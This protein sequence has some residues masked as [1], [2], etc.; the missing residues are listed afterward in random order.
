M[1][2]YSM[3]LS[4]SRNALQNTYYFSMKGL[5]D[6]FAIHMLKIKIKVYFS[7]MNDF[8]KSYQSSLV[9]GWFIK[10]KGI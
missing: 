9:L 6:E 2:S 10:L 3:A 7:K 5:F 1:K 8:N 4:Y